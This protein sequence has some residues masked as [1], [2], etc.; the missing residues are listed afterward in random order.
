L[1]IIKG[2][3]KEEKTGPTPASTRDGPPLD[4]LRK[5]SE[6]LLRKSSGGK[7]VDSRSDNAKRIEKHR[8]RNK[9]R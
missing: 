3:N 5:S 6:D 2:S 7:I 1:L 4:L 9:F 8:K